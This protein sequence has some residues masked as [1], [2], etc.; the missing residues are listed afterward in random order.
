MF[1]TFV[2]QKEMFFLGIFKP[3]F[4]KD[5]VFLKIVDKPP[6]DKLFMKDDHYK[7]G[8]DLSSLYVILKNS[9]N[10]ISNTVNFDCEVCDFHSFIT[11]TIVIYC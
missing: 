3:P 10:I 4:V 2:R 5:N 6:L 7:K 8:T 9:S 11:T 1:W